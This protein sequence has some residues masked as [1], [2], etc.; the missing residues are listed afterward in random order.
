M[1][2]TPLSESIQLFKED[3]LRLAK[4]VNG[5]NDEDYVA[6]DGIL[7]PSIRKFLLDKSNQVNSLSSLL[8]SS[9]EA[10]FDI[11]I[12]EFVL[13]KQ[14]KSAEIDS[15]IS[16]KSADVDSMISAKTAEINNL[17]TD[18]TAEIDALIVDGKAVDSDK[19]DGHDSTY[20]A[21]ASDIANVDNTRDVDKPMSNAVSAALEKY[22]NVD[23]IQTFSQQEKARVWASVGIINPDD[24]RMI[25]GCF[26]IAMRGLSQ[27]TVGFGSAD[28]WSLGGSGG[29]IGQSVVAFALG[30]TLGTYSPRNFGRTTVS[31]QS[32]ASD[33]CVKYHFIEDV[34]TYSDQWITVLGFIRLT[35]GTGNIGV[36]AF[37]I[38]GSGGGE[39]PAVVGTAGSQ[40]T[41]LINNLSSVFKPFA[42]PLRIPSIAGKS[43][44]ANGNPYLGLAFWHS[45]GANYAARSSGIGIQTLSTDMTGIH[46]RRGIVP[47][48][49]I[50]SYM[51]KSIQRE[52]LDCKRFYQL[53]VCGGRFWATGGGQAHAN[54]VNYPQMRT[55]PSITLQ[56]LSAGNNLNSYSLAANG[57]DHS[58]RFEIVA[59]TTGDTYALEAYYRLNAELG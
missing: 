39:S 20:F 6:I 23:T 30:D 34:K 41:G 59:S 3:R 35:S 37:Q 19:L 55:V 21:K 18:K 53:V 15:M 11:A 28:R 32:A 7:V 4:F 40:Q 29:T 8:I 27:T 25:N 1:V 9:K 10:E 24:D 57:S 12:D 14:N 50:G 44:G 38:F 17:I 5:Q 54:T 47:V 22:L 36:E 33:H 13:M 49:A 56:G 46:I 43:I 52:L 48:E 31:G 45:A 42:I 26:D 2:D 58:G 16:S 51:P